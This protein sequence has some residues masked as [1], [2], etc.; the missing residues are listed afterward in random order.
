M[1][2]AAARS[3][4][5][6][7]LRPSRPGRGGRRGRGAE[8]WRWAGSAVD[9]LEL[10]ARRPGLERVQLRVSDDTELARAAT[11]GGTE[12]EPVADR[13]AATTL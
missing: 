1:L 6:S 3:T 7:R 9:E 13:A 5:A 2:A 12:H 10:L 4:S 11:W 8:E